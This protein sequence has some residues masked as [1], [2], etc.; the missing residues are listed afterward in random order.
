LCAALR[1]TQGRTVFISALVGKQ[2]M[3][4][5]ESKG[6]AG[7]LGVGKNFCACSVTNKQSRPVEQASAVR[8]SGL[9]TD[10]ISLGDH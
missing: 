10:Q 9:W 3:P 5:E 7:G 4:G 6:E 8:R 1:G 2:T